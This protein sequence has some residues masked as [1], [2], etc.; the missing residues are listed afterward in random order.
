MDSAT[1]A[2]P[3]A[4]QQ[5]RPARGGLIARLPLEHRLPLVIGT[6]VLVAI[7]ALVAIAYTEMRRTSL[8]TASERLTVVTT[9][10]RDLFQQSSRQIRGQLATTAKAPAILAF[11][12]AQTSGTRE[13]ALATLKETQANQVIAM[14][15]RDSTGRV[16]LA[17]TTGGLSVDSIAVN[18]VL[19]SLE[20]SDSAVAGGF[21]LVKDTI[22]LPVA[23]GVPNAPGLY[24]VQWRRIAGSRRSREQMQRL[25]GLDAQMFLGTAA[26]GRWSNLERV[27]PAP[28]FRGADTQAIRHYVSA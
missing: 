9:Q 25:V 18:D 20:P 5:P 10:L 13:R 12:R 1:N 4:A 21:R 8:R 15:I 26:T 7:A 23:I 3:G 6:L 17:A 11:A 27:V 19:P 22:V 28:P 14:E 16:L 2:G 24:V